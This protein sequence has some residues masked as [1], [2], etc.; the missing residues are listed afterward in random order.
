MYNAHRLSDTRNANNHNA[1]ALTIVR[2]RCA[3]LTWQE[4]SFTQPDC[5]PIETFDTLLLWV[6]SSQRFSLMLWNRDLRMADQQANKSDLYIGLSIRDR[7][8]VV[9]NAIHM[10]VHANKI[11]NS[12]LFSRYT[13]PERP[14]LDPSS[15]PSSQYSEFGGLMRNAILFPLRSDSAIFSLHKVDSLFISAMNHYWI[16]IFDHVAAWITWIQG[17]RCGH[18]LRPFLPSLVDRKELSSGVEMYLYCALCWVYKA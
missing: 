4:S 3:H 16:L 15:R 13:P 14:S 8:L 7:R 18:P 11:I 6:P 12:I 5:I 9:A 10:H 2:K 17:P 1:R